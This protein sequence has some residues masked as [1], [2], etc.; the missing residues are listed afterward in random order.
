MRQKT[1]TKASVA[2][3]FGEEWTCFHCRVEFQ[4]FHSEISRTIRQHSSHD[5]R[6]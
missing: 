6:T 1:L 3:N 5:V 2:E 4:Q